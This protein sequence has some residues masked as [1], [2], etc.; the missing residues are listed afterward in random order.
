MSDLPIELFSLT[1][2]KML[3]EEVR[4]FSR[5]VIFNSDY[6]NYSY[7]L[8]GTAF[9]VSYKKY[10]YVV[11]AKHVIRDIAP[12]NILI[13]YNEY[14]STEFIPFDR[15]ITIKDDE[16]AEDNDFKD[17]VIFQI[18]KKREFERQVNLLPKLDLEKKYAYRSSRFGDELFSI[19]Y[20]SYNNNIEYDE[21]KIKLGQSIF[22][23]KYIGESDLQYCHFAK[24]ENET[25]MDGMSGSPV[26]SFAFNN[27][28]INYKFLGMM[29][30]SRLYLDG[31]VLINALNKAK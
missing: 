13:P 26:Y 22:K 3:S 20:P 18:S 6:D 11:T 31:C 14:D 23:G 16:R 12:D 29:L 19:G 1:V 21:L 8:K 28:S 30:R 27:N 2:L 24:Y 5:P 10:D 17:I 9:V 7:G 25:Y 15:I 4:R